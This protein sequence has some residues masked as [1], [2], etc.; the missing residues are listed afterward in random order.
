MERVL[1]DI[2]D[3][4]TISGGTFGSSPGTLSLLNGATT[5]TYSLSGGN[6]MVSVNGGQ[7][8]PLTG[9]PVTVTSLQFDQFDNGLS[10]AV[11]I[12][13]TMQSVVGGVTVSEDFSNTSVLLSSYD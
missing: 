1:F 10:E 3:A 5:T 6:L 8:A 11:R 13:F 2:R 9:D 7:S 4:D 12:T